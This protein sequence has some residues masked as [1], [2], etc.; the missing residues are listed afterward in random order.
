MFGWMRKRLSQHNQSQIPMLV[1]LGV[2][3]TG[4][5][6]GRVMVNLEGI[7]M[8]IKVGVCAVLIQMGQ[9][10]KPERVVVNAVILVICLRIV[11]NG[12]NVITMVDGEI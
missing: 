6:W 8:V 11:E 10:S 2:T 1:E 12:R 3:R 4:I 9:G 7:F 5:L